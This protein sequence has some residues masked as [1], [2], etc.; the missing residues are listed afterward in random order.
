MLENN[1]NQTIV[2]SG[3]SGAGKTEN[4]R[5]CMNLL[6]SIGEESSTKEGGGGIENKVEQYI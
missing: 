5:F 6:T 2:I 4:A 1:V 3:E